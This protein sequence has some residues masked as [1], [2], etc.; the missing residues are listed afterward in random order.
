MNLAQVKQFA[1]AVG[2]RVE[3]ASGEWAQCK[4][5]LAPFLHD[6][7]RDSHPSCAISYGDNTESVF[8]CFTCESGDLFDLL[9]KLRAFKAKKPR[10]D[11]KTAMDL[12]VQE[13]TGDI[14]LNFNKEEHKEEVEKDVPWPEPYLDGFLLAHKVPMAM[15]YLYARN[16]STQMAY[17]LDIRWDLPR[18]AV[19]FP[20]RNWVGKLVGLRGRYIRPGKD[21]PPY[22]MYG[23]KGQR[24]NLPW[25]G[26]SSVDL[27]KTVVMV[28][29]VFDYTSVARV[30]KNILAPLSSG[31][32]KPKAL[33]VRDAL[34]V[35]TLFDNGQGGDKARD[36]TTKYLSGNVSAHLYPP[37]G[38]GDPGEM[39]IKQLQKVL[40]PY[41]VLDA[42]TKE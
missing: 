2:T 35:V 40:R 25:Y 41:I 39:T 27:D 21:E 33:R 9:T 17:A 36:K 24:N 30:Y 23:F 38:T 20:I 11:L 8:N 29:S 12:W 4:C 3:T 26:E 7:G 31:I 5:P 22:H 14:I 6:S 32:S 15:D 42:L 13:E 16:V 34:D 1:L 28:E 37:A 10:Y 19:C 18:R